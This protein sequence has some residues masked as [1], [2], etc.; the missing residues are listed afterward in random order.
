MRTCADSALVS[1]KLEV[2]VVGF[3]YTSLPSRPVSRNRQRQDARGGSSH[4]WGL[5]SPLVCGVRNGQVDNPARQSR[6][7]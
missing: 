5:L 7:M 3:Q 1:T 6:C 4:H 2:A